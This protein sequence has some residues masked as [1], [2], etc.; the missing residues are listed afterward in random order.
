MNDLQY[1][2]L[3]KKLDDINI[4]LQKIV[5]LLSRQQNTTFIEDPNRKLAKEEARKEYYPLLE[6]AQLNAAGDPS[7][8]N[9]C[10]CGGNRPGGLTG[11]WVCPV[12][13]QQF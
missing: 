11:G 2:D 3:T 10:N 12:H 5:I 13:G 8:Y 1:K 4:S 6:P 7:Q 9:G